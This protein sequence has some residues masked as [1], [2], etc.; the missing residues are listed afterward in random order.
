[1]V[2]AARKEVALSLFSNAYIDCRKIYSIYDFI[3]VRVNPGLKIYISTKKKL[4]YLLA[5]D[6][7][8]RSPELHSQESCERQF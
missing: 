1:M 4:V 5:S 8:R 7:R 3:H 2:C 6:T